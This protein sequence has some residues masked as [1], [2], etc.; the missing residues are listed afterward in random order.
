MAIQLEGSDEIMVVESVQSSTELQV[1]RGA[2]DT[3]PRNSAGNDDDINILGSVDDL[4]CAPNT[5]DID[6]VTQAAADLLLEPSRATTVHYSSS[7]YTPYKAFDDDVGTYWD[8]CCTGYPN[9]W[10]EYSFTSAVTVITYK[11]MTMT[12]ECPAAWHFQGSMNGTAWSTIDTVT[13][14]VC[15][16]YSFESYVVSSPGSYVHYRWVFNQATSGGNGYRIREINMMG[17]AHGRLL[18]P[19]PPH[20]PHLSHLH[21]F[22]WLGLPASL[23]LCPT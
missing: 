12:S 5:C 22:V 4:V 11:I 13:G 18:P 14:Q 6:N 16:E 8:G 2:F 17:H 1:L 21:P 10:L 19:L 3:M 7:S 15:H 23:P 9:Q 20:P